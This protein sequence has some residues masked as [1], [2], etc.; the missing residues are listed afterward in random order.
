MI[1]S[2]W[3]TKK[4]VLSVHLMYVRCWEQT[5]EQGSKFPTFREV[6]LQWIKLDVEQVIKIV[7]MQ[8]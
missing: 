2:V 6:V 4:I 8:K 3:E 1:Q 7:I 5:C